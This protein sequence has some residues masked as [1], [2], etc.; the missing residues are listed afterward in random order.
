MQVRL[1]ADR[2]DQKRSIPW[3]RNFR[4]GRSVTGKD[5]GKR[6]GTGLQAWGNSKPKRVR[7][8]IYTHRFSY[9]LYIKH[10]KE[11]KRHKASNS[12][13]IGDG[14]KYLKS[15]LIIIWINGCG[16]PYSLNYTV[17]Y[18]SSYLPIAAHEFAEFCH[19]I[20]LSTFVR[21]FTDVLPNYFVHS[22]IQPQWKIFQIFST[23]TKQSCLFAVMTVRYNPGP[24]EFVQ[25]S[26]E[27][28]G[29]WVF[30]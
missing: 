24:K 2:M 21:S 29:Q 23:E 28:W 19:F 26:E 5:S 8:V 22:L 13:N 18:S 16:S 12:L 17:I 30:S 1:V 7:G 9:L 11:F 15:F 20:H 25:F 4:F 14:P 27:G 10:D 3:T 6:T